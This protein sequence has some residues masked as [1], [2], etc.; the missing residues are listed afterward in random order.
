[1]KAKIT[2][3]VLALG[4]T[5][6]VGSNAFAKSGDQTVDGTCSASSTSK[7][8][9]GQRDGKLKIEFEVGSNV[10]GQSWGVKLSDNGS[11][12][13]QKTRSSTPM[14]RYTLV[15]WDL[16]VFSLIPSR[17]AISLFGAPSATSASTSRSRFVSS[18]PGRRSARTARRAEAAFGESGDSPRAAARIPEM[19]SSGSASLSR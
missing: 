11:I 12:F 17:R 3:A 13:L 19:S 14:R 2:I 10:K 4:A 1:M 18:S 15:R 9:V 16:T 8:K 6:A 7:L 5:L